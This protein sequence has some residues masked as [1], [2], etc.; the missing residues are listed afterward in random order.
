MR[1]M[2]RGWMDGHKVT[3]VEL[4]P[5]TGRRHQLRMHCLSIGHP[6]VGDYAYAPHSSLETTRMMYAFC[7]NNLMNDLKAACMSDIV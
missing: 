4:R 6:I 2:K 3:L 5:R 1:V 7:F